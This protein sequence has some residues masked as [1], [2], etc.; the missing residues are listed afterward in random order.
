MNYDLPFSINEYISRIRRTGN[1]GN[2]GKAISFFDPQRDGSM[3]SEL[4]TILNQVILLE[5]FN[6][7]LKL[8]HII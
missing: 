6:F 4:I 5:Y 8:K 1:L 2:S 7:K 3:A